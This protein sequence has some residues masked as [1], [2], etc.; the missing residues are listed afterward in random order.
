[1]KVYWRRW[2]YGLVGGAFGLAGAAADPPEFQ[3]VLGLVRSNLVGITESELNRAA[4]AG[5]LQQL[6]PQVRL[7]TNAPTAQ[8]ATTPASLVATSRVF[9][10]AFAYVRIGEVGPGLTQAFDAVVTSLAR[11]NRLE[12]LVLDLRFARGADYAEAGGVADR[13]LATERPLLAWAD[14]TIRSTAKTNA[15]S[16]PT[17]ILVNAETTGAAEALAAVLR[18]TEVG[19]LLG[20]ATGGHARLLKE[21]PLA[22]GQRLQI[23]QTPVRLLDGREFPTTGLKPDI[24]IEG[25]LEDERLFLEDPHRVT[26]RTTGALR[27][28][29][30]LVANATNRPARINEAD[31]VR[32]KRQGFNLDDEE[33]RVSP[34][35]A[36]PEAPVVTDPVLGRALDLLKGLAVFK[37]HRAG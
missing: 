9:D 26:V 14:V 27:R 5:L 24:A 1:M 22:T 33:P 18:Q 6:H 4:V 31:L 7:V 21:F 10:Q 35:P 12:G 23:A 16:W 25:T 20:S 13:F 28:G 37:P 15:L 8:A 2:I 11:S 19:L 36:P 32:M 3:E 29:T 17:T 34:R 30:N